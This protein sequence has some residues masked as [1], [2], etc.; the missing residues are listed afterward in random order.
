MITINEQRTI[1]EIH[2][3]PD[4]SLRG[5]VERLNLG[6]VASASHIVNSLEEKGYL[7]KVGV[8]TNKKYCLTQKA[9]SLEEVI[10]M[11][12]ENLMPRDFQPVMNAGSNPVGSQFTTSGSDNVKEI[13]PFSQK[14]FPNST[15]NADTNNLRTILS[16]NFTKIM[17]SNDGI[18]KYGDVIIL[19][20]I[21]TVMVLPASY[22]VLKN[23]WMNAF[24]PISLILL[25]I[26]ILNKII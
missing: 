2:S 20:G 22:L 1:R 3:N 21:L 11:K 6:G 19:G 24:L 7:E 5:L 14:D 4:I 12:V 16:A 9:L 26:I 15:G 13:E 23:E 18:Q 10:N 25:T 17:T 8:S